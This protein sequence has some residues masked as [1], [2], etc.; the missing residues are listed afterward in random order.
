MTQQEVVDF[1]MS[2][3]S[4]SDWN[5][6]LLEV[7]RRCNGLPWYWYEA[8]IESGKFGQKIDEWMDACEVEV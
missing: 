4:V 5:E 8:F 1:M 7:G 2:A 6:K 3:T